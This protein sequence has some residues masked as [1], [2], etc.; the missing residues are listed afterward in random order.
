M[1]WKMD[2][3]ADIADDFQEFPKGGEKKKTPFY[4]SRANRYHIA[5]VEMILLRFL[6]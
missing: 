2:E 4:L 5:I 6:S 3:L 1:R